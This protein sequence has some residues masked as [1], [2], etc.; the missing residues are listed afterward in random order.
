M[1]NKLLAI[2]VADDIPDFMNRAQKYAASVACVSGAID[3]NHKDA[4]AIVISIR[5]SLDREVLAQ[6]SKLSYVG[7]LGSSTKRIDVDYLVKRN[8]RL[9]PVFGYCDHETAEWVIG[10]IINHFRD[11]AEPRSVYE[12][13]LGLV[14]LGAVGGI[15]ARLGL[16]LGMKVRFFSPSPRRDIEEDGAILSTKEEIFSNCDVVSFHT[17]ARMVWLD[18]TLL[19]L[20]KPG[21][22]LVNT[23]LGEVTLPSVLEQFLKE[24]QDVAVVM[25]EIAKLSY[26]NVRAA[27]Q[28]CDKAAYETAESIARLHETFFKNL[29]VG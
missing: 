24:R 18:S 16:A 14:G 4:D 8:V 17:P 10:Q 9:V 1:F 13:S 19:N 2:D 22:L 20:L 11:R 27:N 5:Q 26:K 6:F 12:K 25:D 7:V 28:N 15:V 3:L 21:A 23:C 29:S